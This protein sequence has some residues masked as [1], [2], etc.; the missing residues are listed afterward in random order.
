MSV[1][2][3][4]TTT[5]LGD[6][7]TPNSYSGQ[8]GKFPKV[9]ASEDGLEFDEVVSGL[10]V[11]VTPITNG[12]DKKF[13]FIDDGKI[14]SPVDMHYDKSTNRLGIGYGGTGGLSAKL[15]IKA[16][17]TLISDIAFRIRNSANTAN[18]L[19][20]NALTMDVFNHTFQNNAILVH[21]LFIKSASSF[22][23]LKW[24]AGGGIIAYKGG[25]DNTIKYNSSIGH[26]FQVAGAKTAGVEYGG[27]AVYYNGSLMAPDMGVGFGADWDVSYTEMIPIFYTNNGNKISLSPIVDPMF[28]ST[29]PNTGDSDTNQMLTVMRDLL[30]SMGLV[31]QV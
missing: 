10:E 23:G 22:G 11:N 14:S 6:T 19:S 29:N 27:L 25:G 3:N 12:I 20:V 16:A 7:D 26:E 9:N 31:R 1:D 5:F 18:I 17:G 2:I 24:Q 28:E 8:A 21:D 13:L 4:I 30:V 15:D